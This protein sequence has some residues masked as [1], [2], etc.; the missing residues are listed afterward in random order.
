MA[1]LATITKVGGRRPN[2]ALFEQ[3]VRVGGATGVASATEWIAKADIGLGE[4]VAVTGFATLGAANVGCNFVMNAQGT[5]VAEGTNKG[6]L[7]VETSAALTNNLLVTV[8]GK[9]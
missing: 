6:D 3:T 1:A 2:G 8:L 4:I 5:G 9:F 7:G